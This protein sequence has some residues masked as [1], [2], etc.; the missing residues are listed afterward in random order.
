M[1]VEFVSNQVPPN[2]VQIEFSNVFSRFFTCDILPFLVSFYNVL[3]HLA[4]RAIMTI[5][6]NFL[7]IFCQMMKGMNRTEG[8]G[9][10]MHIY[11]FSLS[12]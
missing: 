3:I 10:I 12:F 7:N 9:P 5:D 4:E 1:Y 11:V 8:Q 2:I 6:F